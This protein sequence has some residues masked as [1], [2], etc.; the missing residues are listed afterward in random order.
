MRQPL[1]SHTAA[2]QFVLRDYRAEDFDRLWEID[3]LCFVPGIAYTQMELSGYLAQRNAI[4]LVAEF[5]CPA[6]R[7]QI[8]GFLV[9][10]F[11]NQVGRI[12][13]I[14]VLPEA[15]GSGLGSYLMLECEIR[16]RASGC[17]EV[18]LETA[19]NNAP[20]LRMYHKLGYEILRTLPEYYSSESLDAF[21][22][23]K[24]LA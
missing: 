5:G 20:A 10:S 21:Q 23:G 15:R 13:T 18:F 17:K 22:M 3:Q 16:L 14:D 11:H 4:R 2:R 6:Q 9:A 24:Q 7:G 12:L 1:T 8:A 19:V